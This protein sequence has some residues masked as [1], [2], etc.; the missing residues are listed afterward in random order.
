MTSPLVKRFLISLNDNALI[1]FF[2]FLFIIGISGIVAILPPPAPKPPTYRARGLLRFQQPPITI[3]ETGGNLTRQGKASIDERFLKSNNILEPAAQ[4]LPIKPEDLVDDVKVQFNEPP[5]GEEDTGPTEILLQYE[6]PKEGVAQQALQ[7]MMEGMVEQ[8]RLFNTSVL[9][10]RI[11][12]LQKRIDG[13]KQELQAAEQAY[14]R[15]ITEQGSSLVSAEDG[16]LFSGI[17]GAQQQQREIK[18]T[19]EGVEAQIQSISSQLGMTP[20]QAYTASA[21]SADPLVG[22]LRSQLL[23]IETQIAKL[24][25]DLRPQH[26]QMQELLKA[27]AANEKL[28]QQRVQELIGTGN[29]LVPLPG[30][31][32]QTSSLDPAR[33]EL[34]NNLVKLQTQRETLVSQLQSVQKTERELRQQYEQF[35]AKQLERG[36]LQQEL[37]TKQA[38]YNQLLTQLLD[39]QSAEAETV[40]SLTIGNPAFDTKIEPETP[41]GINPIIAIGGGT[42]LGFIAATGVIFLLSILDNRLHTAKEIKD[43]L[44]DREVAFLGELPF[45]YNFNR[46]RVEVPII[47]DYNLSDLHY[48]ELFRTNLRRGAA[49]SAKVILLTSLTDDEGKT[50]VAYN[51]AIAS[52]QAGKRTLLIEGDLRSPSSA[53]YLHLEID[54]DAQLE[55]L[56][57]YGSRSDYLHLVPNV[58]NLYIIPSAGP[59]VKA[60][61][62]LESSEMRRLL[63]D[64]KGRFD[65][66]VIDTPALSTCND[67]L[68]LEPLADGI[69]LVTRPGITCKTPLETQLDSAIE[70]EL[71]LL[72]AVINAVEPK[73]IA[74]LPNDFEDDTAAP[75]S[76]NPVTP[77]AQLTPEGDRNGSASPQSQSQQSASR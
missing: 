74:P 60:A 70:A 62:L 55:P 32:R 27:Q 16:T 7:T 19:L 54:P 23:E 77:A 9:R 40:G 42:V 41:A 11:D 46:D 64:A 24:E 2:T 47:Q 52:A 3:T 71:P 35:P 53:H 38:L 37:Q 13:V 20:D 61:A 56:S 65:L 75:P 67:A 28:L 33:R 34:A 17:S 69:T 58:E 29:V 12:S 26:P 51:L 72:G 73:E 76:I 63:D 18:L 25:D 1:G 48:F 10:S 59:Q 44:N 36:R 15:Y 43:I 8:S 39:A 66:V 6:H 68:L 4:G 57:Y 14:F 22:S 21:L 5:E 30:E 31:I 49:Q 45:V 50:V